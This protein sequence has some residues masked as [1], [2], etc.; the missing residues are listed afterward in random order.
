MPT[1]KTLIVIVLIAVITVGILVPVLILTS[2]PPKDNTP[3]TILI[4]SPTNTY[5]TTQQIAINFSTSDADVDSIWYRIHNDTAGNWVDATN[6]TWTTL[7]ERYLTQDGVFTLYAW[8]NDTAGNTATAVTVCFTIDALPPRVAIV[9]PTNTTYFSETTQ[10]TIELDSPDFNIDT[11]WYRIYNAT[12]GSWVDPTNVTWTAI[13]QRTLGKGIYTLYAWANDT[14]GRFASMQSVT[15]TMYQDIIYS[16]DHVFSAD[17]LVGVYQRVVFQNG[18]F[19]FSSGVLNGSGMVAMYNVTWTTTLQIYGNSAVTGVNVTALSVIN[20]HSNVV[21]AFNNVTFCSNLFLYDNASITLTDAIG[22]YIDTY[23]SSKLVVIHSALYRIQAQDFSR[24]NI[25]DSTL[26]FWSYLWGNSV[27]CLNNCT[28]ADGIEVYMNASLTVSNSNTGP[29]HENLVF[30][31]GN[32]SIDNKSVSGTG[33]YWDPT[34]SIINS[35]ILSFV[36][37]VDLE[38]GANL[39]CKNSNFAEFIAY[40][41]SNMTL[42]NCNSSTI[43]T[44]DRCNVTITNSNVGGFL[45]LRTNGTV[46]L[47][48]VNIAG[49]SHEI[50]FNKGNIAGYNDTFVGA[51]DWVF[52]KLTMGLNVM[53]NDYFYDYN[54]WNQVNLTLI[55]TS[56]VRYFYG[57]D[58]ANISISNCVAP[59]LMLDLR[60]DANGT[61]YKSAINRIEGSSTSNITIFNSTCNEINLNNYAF[62]NIVL[63]SYLIRLNLNHYTSY[64]KSGDSTIDMIYD[65]R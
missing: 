13:G 23:H 7:V 47:E 40:S 39:V 25:S 52:P 21:A 14:Q 8:A 15:F 1:K 53:Y 63:G 49:I 48:N 28:S 42:D 64:Y 16:G 43:Y 22:T 38:A 59:Y 45:E 58:S 29:I 18:A 44:Y 65:Y 6:I 34:I 19:A 50:T 11:F 30:Y 5:Y 57:Y 32:W 62:A 27:V 17:I 31:T 12:D 46:Y 41:N 24:V 61:I 26:V 55:N 54:V 33:S 4:L 35:T 37:I 51:E 20:V 36:D 60:D 9:S 2:Q 3:P 56:R 10:I